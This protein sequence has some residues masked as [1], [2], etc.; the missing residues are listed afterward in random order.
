M[1]EQEGFADANP[2]F[3]NMV[4]YTLEELRGK[5]LWQIGILSDIE[6]NRAAIRQLQEKGHLRFEDSPLHSKAG[7]QVHVEV[8][9]NLY[10]ED[11]QPV[12]QCNFRDI[13]DRRELEDQVREQAKSLADLHRRKDEFLAM[14]LMSCAIRWLL[15]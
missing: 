13:T 3:L 15:S 7:E 4:G 10:Q 2:F 9:A 1:L 8:I 12:I 6:N 14:F 5:E 11:H